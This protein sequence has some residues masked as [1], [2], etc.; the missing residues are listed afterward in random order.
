MPELE[1]TRSPDD[2]KR[3]VLEGVGEL[4]KDGW[5]KQS[6][7]LTAAD[8]RI[9]TADRK[10][11]RQRVVI[12]DQAGG[13]P[14]RFE[15][16]GTFK[17]G[18]RLTVGEEVYEL[19]ASSR[20]KERYALVRDGQESRDGRGRRL[21]RQAP[22]QGHGRGACGRGR[23][24][25]PDRLLAGTAVRRRQRGRGERRYGRGNRRFMTLDAQR[26]LREARMVSFSRHSR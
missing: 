5:M 17:R 16:A 25:A 7:T 13:E 21:A 2:R 3:F 26:Y 14:A 11:L 20:W 19:G 15:A 9:W 10:G 22:R 8:G 24:R 1:L 23:A 6:S 12:A 4:R 18:G